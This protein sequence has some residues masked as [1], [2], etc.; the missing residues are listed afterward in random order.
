MSKASK[1]LSIHLTDREQV[2]GIV[3]LLFSLFLLPSLLQYANGLLPTPLNSAWFNFLYFFLNFI[4]IF[5][6]FGKF[7]HRSL[8]YTG[9]HFWDFLLAVILGFV[10]H[11][12]CSWG[13][14]VL[15]GRL[16]PDYVNLN[17]SSISQMSHTNFAVMVLGT[18]LLVPVAEEALHRG[19]IFGSLYPKSHAAAYLLS[20]VIFSAI[21]I[22]GYL[23]TYS[24]THLALAFVQYLPAGL[25]LAWVYR[26]SG[27][28]FAPMVLHALINGITLLTM[29]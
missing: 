4:C 25:I 21:H 3:Y 22:T 20:A 2:W 10:L 5:W 23:G 15:T 24:A 27:S 12:L 13:F 8:G 9:A 16:F 18:V 11:F 19:L 7:F 1:K 6:I 29:R 17:D 14:S 26:K 28:I